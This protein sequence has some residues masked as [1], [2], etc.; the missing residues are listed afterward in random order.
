LKNK[1]INKLNQTL[2]YKLNKIKLINY[3]NK[4]INNYNKIKMKNNSLIKKIIEILRNI[5]LILY[6]YF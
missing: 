6:Y 1:K 3:K 4:I 5:K 2:L